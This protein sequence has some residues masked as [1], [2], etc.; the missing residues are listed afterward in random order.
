MG[1]LSHIRDTAEGTGRIFLSVQCIVFALISINSLSKAFC[2]DAR[3]LQS[4]V[5]DINVEGSPMNIQFLP[6][7]IPFGLGMIFCVSAFLL[8][9]KDKP[10]QNWLW[11]SGDKDAI[12]KM[13]YPD[14]KLA[15]WIRIYIFVLGIG[16]LIVSGWL[17]VTNPP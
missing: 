13:A 2:R 9:D 11:K 7:L 3:Q 6:L 12:R 16:L 5:N 17:Y 8:S 1:C 4:V 14:N 10:E 15:L